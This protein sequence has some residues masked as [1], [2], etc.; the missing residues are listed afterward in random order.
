MTGIGVGDEAPDF[1]LPD[2]EGGRT[3]LSELVE[4]RGGAV[5]Y[6]FPKAFTSGCTIEV[7]DFSAH[8]VELAEAGLAVVGVS[9]DQP[10]PLADFARMHDGHSLLVS[11]ADSAVHRAYGVLTVRDVDGEPVEKVRR[12]TYLVGPDRTVRQVWHDVTVDGH[13][14]DVLASASRG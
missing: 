13:V 5:V 10:A 11:D 3:R 12:T 7:G 2:S 4:G 14:L 6:F 9:R 8:G 1:D